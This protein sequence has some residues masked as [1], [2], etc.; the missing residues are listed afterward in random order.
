MKKGLTCFICL[1]CTLAMVGCGKGNKTENK[2]PEGTTESKQDK[3]E[4]GKTGSKYFRGYEEDY[5]LRVNYYKIKLPVDYKFTNTTICSD[6]IKM[7]TKDGKELGALITTTKLS[8]T[9]N[10]N[11]TITDIRE[12]F[13]NDR[14]SNMSLIYPAYDKTIYNDQFVETTVGDKK[15][16]LDK[17]VATNPGSEVCKYAV[18]HFFLDDEN[19]IPCEF[20]LGST[21][22]EP[23]ELAK[24]AEEMI[25]MIE[26]NTDHIW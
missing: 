15:A 16:L 2:A 5:K 26:E 6:S 17:G 10:P 7:V 8:E 3:P 23:D 11:F 12:E 21:E 9:L 14:N 18:Y 20:F 22:I 24:I 4:D 19:K 25:G 1:C 13:K